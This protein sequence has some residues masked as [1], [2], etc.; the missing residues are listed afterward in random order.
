MTLTKASIYEHLNAPTN[1]M[2]QHFV[3]YFTGDTLDTFVWELNGNGATP[4]NTS[5][6]KDTINGGYELMPIATFNVQMTMGDIRQFNYNGSAFIAS[7]SG[8]LASGRNDFLWGFTGAE[9][10]SGVPSGAQSKACFKHDSGT[11]GFAG[12]CSQGT[13][14]TNT[15]LAGAELTV[16]NNGWHVCKGE[17]KASSC[18]FSHAGVLGI[19]ITANLPDSKMQLG[20]EVRSIG[21]STGSLS[22]SINYFE[23]WNT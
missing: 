5:G 21:G 13:G 2:K 22:G 17:T 23:A 20:V 6:M 18:E 4:H 1:V 15:A 16:Y 8:Y 10:W 9:E 3:E 11:G 14:Q 19:T 12:S 7:V